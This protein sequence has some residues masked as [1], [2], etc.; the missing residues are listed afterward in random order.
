MAKTAKKEMT[1][2]TNT[3]STCGRTSAQIFKKY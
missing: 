3:K 2:K 1:S